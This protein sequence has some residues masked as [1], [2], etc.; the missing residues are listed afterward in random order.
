MGNPGLVVLRAL[1]NARV[2]GPELAEE[3]GVSREAVWKRIESLRAQGFGIVGT[4]TGY[5]LQEIPEF[6]E[7][8]IALSVPSKLTVVYEEVVESTNS[9][10]REFATAGESDIVVVAG[11]QS[12][13][14]G[15]LGRE[16]ESPSGGIWMSIV[17]TP[18]L[19]TA[20]LPVLTHAAA[21]AVTKAIRDLG[22][23]AGIKWP[24]D[25]LVRDGSGTAK[26]AGILTEIQGEADQV[27]WAVIGIGINA[28][29]PSREL[30]AGATSLREIQGEVTRRCLIGDI[31]RNLIA[32]QDDPD[33]I[34]TQWEQLAMTI[35][36]RVRVETSG[37]SVEG[38]AVGI[39]RSG[40]LVIATGAGEEVVHAGD[41]YHL[42]AP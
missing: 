8:A 38:E 36:E 20:Q 22:V 16:W 19:P 15:R 9:V 37:R 17:L 10:A 11:E 5:E 4:P 41:C 32:I 27:H 7:L 33:E 26:L 21:V 14:R 31:L 3:L 2:S 18:R 34:L 42:R 24:N 28:N 23:N 25:V 1:E 13:G 35:G 12:G 29:V 40:A 6:S 30:P 39:L